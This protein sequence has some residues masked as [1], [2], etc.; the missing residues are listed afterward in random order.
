MLAIDAVAART[1]SWVWARPAAC[2]GP[3][4]TPC[5]ACSATVG[6]DETVEFATDP[7]D[8]RDD[9]GP[10]EFPCYQPSEDDLAWYRGI[11]RKRE[12]RLW[13]V[14]ISA[15]PTLA[16]Q[17]DDLSHAFLAIRDPLYT[18][19]GELLGEHADE[20]RS[21]DATTPAMYLD[22]R[23]AMLDAREH[24]VN[25]RACRCGGGPP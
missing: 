25:G 13:E 16:E 17:L 19:V 20:V 23:Q 22:R 6:P 10:G 9:E 2:C 3:E 8:L 24:G 7:S 14:R 4:A 12:E 11:C 5:V 1:A 18:L 15:G 21:L